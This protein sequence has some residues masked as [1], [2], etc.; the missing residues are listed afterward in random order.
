MGLSRGRQPNA[1]SCWIRTAELQHWGL[2]APRHSL[3]LSLW[4]RGGRATPARLCP[5]LLAPHP[6]KRGTNTPLE[7]T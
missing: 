7:A 5:S 3:A 4:H 6:H 1:R 2:S